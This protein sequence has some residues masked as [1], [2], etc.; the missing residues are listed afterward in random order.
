MAGII[1][2]EEKKVEEIPIS[3]L[4][5]P[6]VSYKSCY[7]SR[8]VSPCPIQPLDTNS[9]ISKATLFSPPRPQCT[10]ERGEWGKEEKKKEEMEE[11]DRHLI[12][13]AVQ[14]MAPTCQKERGASI[15]S[16]NDKRKLFVTYILQYPRRG[17]GVPM[18]L[19]KQLSNT[20]H[21]RLASPS[22]IHLP[23][24]ISTHPNKPSIPTP[25]TPL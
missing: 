2:L 21:P 20:A 11:I 17:G 15:S 14:M 24:T 23:Y 16:D 3:P 6:G 13:R 18:S 10:T 1:N 9:N 5:N 25:P 19:H 7:H 4:H 22:N 8:L 12:F